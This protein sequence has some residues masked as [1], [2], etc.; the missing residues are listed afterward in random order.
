[1]PAG[2]K[3]SLLHERRRNQVPE[4]PICPFSISAGEPSSVIG[5]DGKPSGGVP[6]RAAPCLT[7]RCAAFTQVQGPNGPQPACSRLMVTPILDQLA[8]MV[9]ALVTMHKADLESRGVKIVAPI[10]STSTKQ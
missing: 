4:I 2:P 5:A 8:G 7:T 9:E 6:V 10:P 3:N 1:M